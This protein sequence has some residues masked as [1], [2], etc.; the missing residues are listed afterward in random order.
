MGKKQIL[1]VE[2]EGIVAMDIREI[3]QGLGY[4]VP[5]CVASAEEALEQVAR[6]CPDLALMDIRLK[7]QI[8]GL[9][10]ARL[11][12]ERYGV[13]SIFLTSYADREMLERAKAADAY[14]YIL[15][16]F[17]ERELG[18]ALEMA[19]HRIK[20]ET[21]PGTGCLSAEEA[22][23]VFPEMEIGTLGKIEILLDGKVV[24]ESD[25]MTRAQRELLA[26]LVAAPQCR[27]SREE[28]QTFLWPDSPTARA[29]SSFDSLLLR[30][31]KTIEG[32]GDL[33]SA[34][35]YLSQRR[36]ILTLEHCRVDAVDF[37][38]GVQQGLR[39]LGR[40]DYRQAKERLA[41]AL[42]LWDGP[43]MLRTCGSDLASR[44]AEELERLYV[45]AALAL[46]EIL[47]HEA[48]FGEA[49]VVLQRAL[50]LDGSNDALVRNLCRQLRRGGQMARVRQIIEQYE[51]NLLREGYGAAEVA[52]IIAALA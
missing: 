52:E 31:R 12:R 37:R 28:V 49:A 13:P 24:V 11:L 22:G 46:S 23:G 20:R 7:G 36:G 21:L 4:R 42:G 3:L 38:D 45:E 19:F 41:F 50:E 16:P 9:E 27:L 26:M 15:K 17:D 14:G 33:A 5:A 29:R 40:A 2:D 44:L 43:F 35:F 47:S 48:R 1:V 30:L 25:Q 39:Y 6:E 32:S 8:D 10:G 18:I 51:V 34:A